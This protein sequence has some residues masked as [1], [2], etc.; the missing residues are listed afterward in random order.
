MAKD[1]YHYQVK[2]ALEKEGWTITHDPYFI[3]LGKR[4]G[5]IDLGAEILGAERGTEKIAVEIKS[6]SGVSDVDEFED[7]L[8]QFLLYK[9]A[10]IK[11]EPDRILYLAMPR[12]F[13]NDLFDDAFFLEVL[14]IYQVHIVIYDYKNLLIEQWIK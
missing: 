10:L 5:Y 9:L 2:E 1:K 12:D 13:Y 8:G 7:A 4:K 6:F 3:R 14:K 11:K